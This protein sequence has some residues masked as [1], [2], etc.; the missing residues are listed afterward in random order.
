MNLHPDDDQD[1]LVSATTDW[2]TRHMP[3]DQARAR[4][5]GLWRGL[6]DMGWT[7]MTASEASSGLGLDHASEALV[8]AELGRFLAPV[9]LLSSALAARWCDVSD[10]TALALATEGDAVRVLDGGGAGYAVATS[11]DEATLIFVPTGLDFQIGLDPTTPQARLISPDTL[12]TIEGPRPHRHLTLLAAAFGVGVADAARDMAADYAKLREQFGKPIGSFQGVKHPCADMAVRCAVARSQLCYA[13][14]AL[15]EGA[16]DAGFHV[17]AA[18]R[19]ADL[20]ALDN[21]RANIQVHGG[22]GMTD[23]A[24]PHLLLKRAHV[25]HFIA[26]IDPLGLIGGDVGQ[27]GASRD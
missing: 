15:D 25:L 2:L 20:A 17:A 14:C 7:A 6:A 5:A 11:S 10:R 12:K 1:A 16:P 22:V 23:A 8:F 21:A 4:P 24:S 26:P 27:N 19:L 18:K 9:S 13:A 3:L